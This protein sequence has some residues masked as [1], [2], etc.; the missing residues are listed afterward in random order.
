MQTLS[1]KSFLTYGDP[2]FIKKKI[3]Q[4]RNIVYI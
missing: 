3:K 4:L 1:F 2:K